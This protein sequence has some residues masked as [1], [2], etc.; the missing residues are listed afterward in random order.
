MI[1]QMFIVDRNNNRKR[2]GYR[3]LKILDEKVLR[4]DS[5]IEELYEDCNYLCT[6]D[7]YDKLADNNAYLY[8]VSTSGIHMT[9]YTKSEAGL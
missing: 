9:N 6:I 1:L 2:G 3:M 4:T 7:S 5:E 8:C